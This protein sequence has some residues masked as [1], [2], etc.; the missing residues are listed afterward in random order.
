MARA[1]TLASNW[2][3]FQRSKINKYEDLFFFSV[4]LMLLNC[5]ENMLKVRSLR[6]CHTETKL[7]K[8]KKIC[9]FVGFCCFLC[10]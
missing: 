6:K 9:G 8:A 10:F 2:F 7:N 1:V 3:P 5:F 4:L